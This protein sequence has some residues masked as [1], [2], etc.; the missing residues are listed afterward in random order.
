MSATLDSLNAI[1]D[2]LLTRLVE[3][4]ASAHPDIVTE[5]KTINKDKYRAALIADIAAIEARIAYQ[6]RR[7]DGP[8]EMYVRGQ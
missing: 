5:G 1:R 3:I 6:E 8:W 2:N 7:D 4:T